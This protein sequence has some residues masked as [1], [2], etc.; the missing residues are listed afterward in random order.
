MALP[1]ELPSLNSF[2][3]QARVKY[4]A[5]AILPMLAL[6]YYP[7]VNYSILLFGQRAL[8]ETVPVDPSDFLRGDYVLL[9]Y[10]IEDVSD[11]VKYEERDADYGRLERE[12][13]VSLALDSSGVASVTAVSDKRPSGL[14]LKGYIKKDWGGNYT[15]NYR[16][17][18]YYIPEGT[19]RALE[20]AINDR[21]VLADVRILRGR[22]VI[23]KLEVPEN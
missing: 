11:F 8:L 5:A 19:G 3:K 14:Y 1:F 20:E 12:S 16:L 10:E 17:G 13:F 22:G 6:L 21:K 2:L 4:A 18:V 7:I 9:D 15:C 23:K